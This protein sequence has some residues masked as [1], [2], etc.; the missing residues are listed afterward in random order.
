MSGLTAAEELRMMEL[1]LAILQKKRELATGS[2]KDS[3]P[4]GSSKGSGLSG[5]STPDGGPSLATAPP[6][7]PPPHPPSSST[8]SP[9]KWVIA[10]AEAA[11]GK[12]WKQT[13][14]ANAGIPSYTVPLP[15]TPVDDAENWGEA[16][17]VEVCGKSSHHPTKGRVKEKTY[18]AKQTRP[19]NQKNKRSH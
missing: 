5:S 3:G 4:S 10:D 8:T 12:R 7:P 2:S 1:E 9:N 15:E 16:M 18:D 13:T 19:A 11:G 17:Q 6:P 14:D